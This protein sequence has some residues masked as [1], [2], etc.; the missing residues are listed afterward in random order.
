MELLYLYVKQIP[1]LKFDFPPWL[2]RRPPITHLPIYGE[3]VT[4]CMSS[5]PYQYGKLVHVFA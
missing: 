4:L 1:T 5:Q 2:L 3:Y